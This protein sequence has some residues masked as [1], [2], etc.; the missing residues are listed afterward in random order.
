VNRV[1]RSA[2]V[3]IES[4]LVTTPLWS[5]LSLSVE[6]TSLDTTLRGSPRSLA[7]S[8]EVTRTRSSS[9]AAP[10]GPAERAWLSAATS[11]RKPTPVNDPW[12]DPT[13]P[14]G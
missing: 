3:L 12:P 4:S 6:A 5:A 11:Q 14:A 7:I 10:S 1:T 9:A 8:S 2:A 13:E